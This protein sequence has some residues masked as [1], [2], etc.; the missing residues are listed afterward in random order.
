LVRGQHVRMTGGKLAGDSVECLWET[1][2]ACA[3]GWELGAELEV[4]QQKLRRSEE[5]LNGQREEIE[6]LIALSGQ[7]QEA[8]ASRPVIDQAKGVL[9]A[10][11]WDDP[12][13]ASSEACGCESESQRQGA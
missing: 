9:V 4:A 12:G 5:K 10:E 13:K 6:R 7:L 11:T 1:E 2:H 8:L 3:W